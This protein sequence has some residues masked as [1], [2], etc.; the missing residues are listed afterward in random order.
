[1]RAFYLCLTGAALLLLPPAGGTATAQDGIANA[2]RQSAAGMRAQSRRM[3][4]IAQNIANVD[5]A[6]ALPGQEPYRRKII[7]FKEAYNPEAGTETVIV[8]DVRRDYNN[9]LQPR[10]DPAHPA[11]DAEGYVLYPNVSTSTE[12]ADMREAE[13]SYEANLNALSTARGMY[14]R[15]VDLLR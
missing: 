5:S 4:I 1:M 3:N 14:S 8:Q 12:A 13:R 11:A 15:T 2:M 7:F 10:F 9:S 6:G